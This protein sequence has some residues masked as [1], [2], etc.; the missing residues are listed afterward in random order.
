MTKTV[1]FFLEATENIAIGKTANQSSD[2]NHVTLAKFAVDG[3]FNSRITHTVHEVK[4]WWRVDLGQTAVVQSVT[5]QNRP[6]CW[7]YTRLNPFDVRVGDS[8]VNNGRDNKLCVQ[9]GSFLYAGQVKR[10]QCMFP[11]PG[12][13][14]S[15]H[16]NRRVSLELSEVQ[17]YGF[18]Y[19]D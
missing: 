11:V 5:I 16:L 1:V 3:K 19:I 6:I 9:N 17:V 2:Y 12:R 4:P 13:Y 8:L 10:F 18:F 14:V 7:C 15:I